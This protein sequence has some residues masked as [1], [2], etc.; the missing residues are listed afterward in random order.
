LTPDVH[1]EV[2][3]Q[4]T[5]SLKT[6][7]VTDVDFS[8]CGIGSVALGHLSDWVRDATAALTKVD[9]RGNKELDEEAVDALRAAAPETCEILADY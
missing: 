8:S 5:D 2:F 3:K 4:L 7:Q 6:S 9:V 1:A